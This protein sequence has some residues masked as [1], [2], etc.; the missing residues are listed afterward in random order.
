MH[1]E[2][3]ICHI[4]FRMWMFKLNHFI[5]VVWTVLV[6]FWNFISYHR[7]FMVSIQFIYSTDPCRLHLDKRYRYSFFYWRPYY[8]LISRTLSGGVVMFEWLRLIYTKVKKIYFIER[9]P[10]YRSHI[11][12]L[13]LCVRK[14]HQR[15]KNQTEWTMHHCMK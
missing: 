2:C 3:I 7:P 11:S 4:S 5:I 6:L 15:T 8:Y 10:I 14:Y 9:L 1:L 13:T 12:V